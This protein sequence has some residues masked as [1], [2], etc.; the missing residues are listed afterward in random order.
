MTNNIPILILYCL[1]LILSNTYGQ[2]FKTKIDSKE[3][4]SIRIEQ[5]D[6][7]NGFELFQENISKPGDS[8][9]TKE[10]QKKKRNHNNEIILTKEYSDN[11]ALIRGSCSQVWY[12]NGKKDKIEIN[13]NVCASQQQFEETITNYTEKYYSTKFIVSNKLLLGDRN[14]IPEQISPNDYVVFM[15]SLDNVFVRI[16]VL[17]KNEDYD[18]VE[19]ISLF[20]ANK[21]KQNLSKM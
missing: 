20:L 15:F 3:I 14:W 16:Y 19:K 11:T 12:R 6:L 17:I 18:E 7:P 10:I 5:S 21:I 1:N 8:P 2:N 13:I 9:N 4:N